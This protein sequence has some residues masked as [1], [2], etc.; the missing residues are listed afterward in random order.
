MIDYDHVLIQYRESILDGLLR[1]LNLVCG[2]CET[3][4]LQRL[5]DNIYII[6]AEILLL[7][8]TKIDWDDFVVRFSTIFIAIARIVGGLEFVVLGKLCC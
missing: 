1:F 7:N 8:M 6:L 5:I 2:Q 3:L 4:Y